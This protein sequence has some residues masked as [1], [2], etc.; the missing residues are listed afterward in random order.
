MSS[1]TKQ[2][3]KQTTTTNAIK[4]SRIAPN[5]AKQPSLPKW[6]AIQPLVAPSDL[7]LTALLPDQVLTIS[8]FWTTAL[9]K[10]YVA[11]LATLPLITTPGTPQKGH[12]VRVNDRYQVE[13]S[14]F[15]DRLWSGTALKELVEHPTID[16]REL[17]AEDTKE[18]WG[19]EVL[20][21]NSNIRVYRYSKGQFFDQHY[22]DSN[23]ISFP[24]STSP[25]PIPAR[26]TW[27]LLLYLS[28]P[29]TGCQGGETVFYPEAPGKRQVAPAPVIAALEVGMALL[30]RH[31]K[32]CLLHEGRE[33]LDGEKWVIRSDLCVRR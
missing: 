31:G 5:G 21:L 18:L 17:S 14:A 1:K 23:I 27:T 7:T 16:G 26:T 6:P 20:G 32:D 3:K 15:A 12:A 10:S 9:C 28:S 2:T 11:F 8:R 24:T 25:I 29:A 33:V 13:D 19:G 22:D 4:S 30:H